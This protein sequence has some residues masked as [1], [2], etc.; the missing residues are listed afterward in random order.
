MFLYFINYSAI[1]SLYA[2]YKFNFVPI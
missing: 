1:D 2:V